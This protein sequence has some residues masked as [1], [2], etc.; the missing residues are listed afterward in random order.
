MR[1][2]VPLALAVLLGATGCVSV[3]RT[4]AAP[5]QPK[6]W[7]PAGDPAPP[8]VHWRRPPEPPPREELATIGA[9]PGPSREPV[10]QD[11]RTAERPA[12]AWAVPKPPARRAPAPADGP[13]RP[14]PRPQPPA[15]H[16]PPV[17]VP[18]LPR[19][20]YGMDDVCRASQGVTDPAVTALCQGV[21]GR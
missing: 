10:R 4:V 5:P 2:I 8:P 17:H 1:R 18:A 7:A 15:A 16:V 9:L 14:R 21:Y 20:A 6:Q 11:R 19:P 12:R 3:P 13:Q